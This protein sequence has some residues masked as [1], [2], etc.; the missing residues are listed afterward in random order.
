[1]E[2]GKSLKTDTRPNPLAAASHS[3]SSV[4]GSGYY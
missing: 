4:R 3:V 2:S 1:M